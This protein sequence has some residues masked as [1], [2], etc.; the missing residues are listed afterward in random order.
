M[1][2]DGFIIDHLEP[3]PS[4]RQGQG[5]GIDESSVLGRLA[6]G[7]IVP[8]KT[9]ESLAGKT[10]LLLVVM[11]MCVG[12]LVVYSGGAGWGAK[13]FHDEEYFL[14]RQLLFS[15]AGLGVIFVVGA[16][17]YKI[18]KRFSKP[19]L[20]ASAAL[21]AALLAMK[22]V[23][24][25]EGAAR[26]IGYGKFK[27]QASDLA[28]YALLLR[29]AT[30]LAEK[31]SFVKD[32]HRA[33]YPMITVVLGVAGLVALEPNFSTAAVMTGICLIVMYL[34]GADVK[35]LAVTILGFAPIAA[36]FAIAAPYRVAR[37]LAFVG[38]GSDKASYQIEQALIGLGNGG[39]FG[40]GPGA[41]KQRELFL[42]ASYNDFI[43]AVLGEEYGFVGATLIILLFVG[44][45]ICGVL[46][47]RNAMDDF[48]R[49]LAYGVTTAIGVYAFVNAAVAC[50]LLPTTGLPMPFVS[51]GGSATLFNS[52]GVGLLISVSREKKRL[53]KNAIARQP[54]GTAEEQGNAPF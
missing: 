52:F 20:V 28:K 8:K 43:F 54:S 15:I 50:H 2:G 21:L 31:K 45:V 10:L 37:L 7:D 30:M 6:E 41:S 26:W 42:P 17:D 3:K 23:G 5:G 49:H 25:I 40:L 46:I 11:L 22:A 1:N 29:L 27:F 18:F 13:K 47:A 32:L 14:W 4:P 33:Y 24:V 51:Y 44:V 36:G 34:G 53:E 35:H 12:V 16:V 38:E 48:G 9:F 19:I 39:I